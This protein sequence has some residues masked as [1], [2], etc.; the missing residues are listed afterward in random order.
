MHRQ[1]VEV[2]SW[3]WTRSLFDYANSLC[4]HVA[5]AWILKLGIRARKLCISIYIH[6]WRIPCSWLEAS[7]CSLAWGGGGG[8]GEYLRTVDRNWPLIWIAF[9]F[10]RNAVVYICGKFAD[11]T[12]WY[13]RLN[14]L[15]GLL[16]LDKKL[17]YL[18]CISFG[19]LLSLSDLG[20]EKV[21]INLLWLGQSWIMPVLFSLPLSFSI[22]GWVI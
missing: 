11:C 2:Y 16:L 5:S 6:D 9:N 20:A 17:L 7:K 12:H 19:C 15:L 8:G 18:L 10:I 14:H 21:A 4:A 1:H 3:S 13:C 22:L